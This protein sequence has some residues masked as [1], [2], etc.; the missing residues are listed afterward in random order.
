M[1]SLVPVLAVA[2]VVGSCTRAPPR[3]ADE[4]G[5]PPPALERAELAPDSADA[6]AR[7]EAL[8]AS[9]EA[10][11]WAKSPRV[12]TALRQVPRHLFAPNLTLAEAYVDQP[13]PIGAGQTI[14]QPSIVAQMT[15]VLDTKP[16]QRVLEIG[17]GSGYQAAILSTLVRE[18]YTIEIVPE[19]GERATRRLRDLGYAN[20]HVRIG[21][22]YEGWPEH[23]PFDRIVLTAA[24]PEIPQAL[25]DQLAD[26]GILVAPV[27]EE[28]AAQWLVRVRKNGRELKRERLERVHFVPMIRDR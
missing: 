3:G 10:A 28:D 9:I 24:P 26:G 20:V 16:G 23:A 17:T 12:L 4:A 15:E 22:G 5:A 1:R 14:S 11:G 13:M 18:V 8:V 27:G 2:L 7:R 19:L 6:R 21:D 25:L